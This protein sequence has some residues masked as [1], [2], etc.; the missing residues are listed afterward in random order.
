MAPGGTRTVRLDPAARM[1]DGARQLV[2]VLETW[3]PERGAELGANP[4]L[5]LEQPLAD[6]DPLRWLRHHPVLLRVYWNGRRSDLE[7]AGVGICAEHEGPPLEAL[8]E[9][10][11]QVATGDA[12]DSMRIFG[13]MRFDPGRVP[14]PA[15]MSFGRARF[16]L[17]LLEMR[18]DETGVTLAVNLKAGAAALGGGNYDAQRR[19]AMRALRGDVPG[20]PMVPRGTTALATDDAAAWTTGVE[21]L[22]RYIE[23]GTIEKAVLARAAERAC[24]TDPIRIMEHL[25]SEHP[26]A[27]HFLVQPSPASTFLG[28]SPEHLYERVGR[29]VR[30]EALAG[31]RPRGATP[32]EDAAL[33]AELF[34]SEKDLREHDHVRRHVASTLAA[35][36]DEPPTE[37][38]PSVRTLPTLHHL[39]TPIEGTL[40]P[41]VGDAALLAALHPT[42]AVCGTPTEA[43]R[44]LLRDEENFDRGLYAGPVG[45]F[46]AERSEVAVGIR[47][48]L[49]RGDS[50]QLFAGA[51]I[52]AGSD[53][54]AEWQETVQKMSALER[55]LGADDAS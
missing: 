38:A 40:R 5:R 27:C 50:V 10:L 44:G 42:P 39:H 17:P 1:A 2:Q 34:G 53:P 46:G 47:S 19:T 25:R 16:H 15:W 8:D 9:L 11:E 14:D 22:L 36:C 23:A 26:D 51:G 37:G 3:G 55:L 54:D 7:L 32:E 29:L 18:R 21:T 13:T 28:A 52:V 43:A 12:I 30:T 35:L 49:I 33:A 24:E 4:F 45:C 20:L 31:T 6:G 41:G 48:A